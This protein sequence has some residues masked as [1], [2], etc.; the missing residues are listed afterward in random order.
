M[1]PPGIR[2]YR[3]LNQAVKTVSAFRVSPVVLAFLAGLLAACG[4][5]PTPQS[6]QAT[7]EAGLTVMLATIQA[8][9]TVE[10]RPPTATAPVKAGD[11]PTPTLSPSRI[12][13]TIS[14]DHEYY[15]V[16]GRT[17]RQIFSSVDANS[18]PGADGLFKYD[19]SP[20][21]YDVLPRGAYCEIAWAEINLLMLVTLPR[22]SSPGGLTPDLL[23]RWR[24]F[25]AG[26]AAHEQ[27]HVDNY[28]ARYEAFKGG[29]YSER[30]SDCEELRLRLDSRSGHARVLEDRAQRAFHAADDRRRERMRAPV[31]RQIEQ[32]EAELAVA[33]TFVERQSLRDE[34]Q[35]LYEESSWLR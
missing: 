26:V 2:R 7:A 30:F 6:A 3:R 13:L 27:R 17:T 34:L 16:S 9:A 24:I 18:P 4:V 29:S 12:R 33:T 15:P 23:S 11:L 35:K 1:P 10:A 19:P 21:T 28:I 8:Q 5:N 31:E 32:T 14:L 25:E 20:L 22:H